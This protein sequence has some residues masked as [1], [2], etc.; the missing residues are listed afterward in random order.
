MGALRRRDHVLRFADKKI[1]A[2]CGKHC[3]FSMREGV[4]VGRRGEI[5]PEKFRKVHVVWAQVS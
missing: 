1:E 2:R 3:V 5:V 4:K